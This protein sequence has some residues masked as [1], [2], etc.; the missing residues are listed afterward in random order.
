MDEAAWLTATDPTP[1]LAF[2]RNAERA[3]ERK[4][5]LFAVAC[6]REV[7][8]WLNDIRIREAVQ[9]AERYADGLATREEL[10]AAHRFAEE[11]FAEADLVYGGAL[12]G[13][14]NPNR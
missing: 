9:T 2:L 7:W 6:F 4:L 10:A 3:S 1:M 8:E 11:F 13:F 14:G 12:A 5:R